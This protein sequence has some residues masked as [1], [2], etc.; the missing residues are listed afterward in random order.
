VQQ[1]GALQDARSPVRAEVVVP[2][3]YA[4]EVVQRSVVV[5]FSLFEEVFR[6]FARLGCAVR[7]SACALDHAFVRLRKV[8]VER[9]G[10][11][12]E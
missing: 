4:C 6:C 1:L 2:A 11:P 5:L 3:G 8:V 9:G 12:V 7:G 10:E